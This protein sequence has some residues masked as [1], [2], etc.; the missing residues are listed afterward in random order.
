MHIG[1]SGCQA[2]NAL[3]SCWKGGSHSRKK[4]KIKNKKAKKE[5]GDPIQQKCQARLLH[6]KPGP[7]L[8]QFKRDTCQR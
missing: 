7:R 8:I 1:L 3:S 6:K 5:K 2:R 4:I